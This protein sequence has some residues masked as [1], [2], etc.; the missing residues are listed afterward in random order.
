MDRERHATKKNSIVRFS[1][2]EFGFISRCEMSSTKNKI[3]KLNKKG[4][5]IFQKFQ[6]WL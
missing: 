4:T 6:K 3:K 2:C 5:K 1:R